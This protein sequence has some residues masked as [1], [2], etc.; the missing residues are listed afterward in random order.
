MSPVFLSVHQML[1]N[2][3]TKPSGAQA[4]LGLAWLGLI[5]DQVQTLFGQTNSEPSFERV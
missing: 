1:M 3:V 5:I 2:R 4:L